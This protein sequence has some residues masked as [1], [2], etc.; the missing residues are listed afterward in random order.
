MSVDDTAIL[1]LDKP[2]GARC[3]S[4]RSRLEV[5]GYPRVEGTLPG[6]LHARDR[7]AN[8]AAGQVGQHW[9]KMDSRVQVLGGHLSGRRD[10][11]SP[12]KP[13]WFTGVVQGSTSTPFSNTSPM[14][15]GADDV[16]PRRRSGRCPWR[17]RS[18]STGSD[19][20]RLTDDCGLRN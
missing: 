8:S 4:R 2:N 9:G 11:P 7:D 5:N 18:R 1:N 17:W 16:A 20:N 13:G 6:L 15:A 19:L 14:P 3:P 10:H 12:R